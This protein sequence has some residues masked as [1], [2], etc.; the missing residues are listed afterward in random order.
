M[1]EDIT[2]GAF[3]SKEDPDLRQ[4]S[5]YM[6]IRLD[7]IRD[8]LADQ[9]AA[10]ALRIYDGTYAGAPTQIALLV[11]DGAIRYYTGR[12]TEEVLEHVRPPQG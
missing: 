4:G 12:G 6:E 10:D 9:P 7:L 3:I 8:Y 2:T 1:P 5:S 11:Q